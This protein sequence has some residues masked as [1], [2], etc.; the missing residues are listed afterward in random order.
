MGTT[1][2]GCLL[3]GIHAEHLPGSRCLYGALFYVLPDG[4]PFGPLM[5]GNWGAPTS[6]PR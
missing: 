1:R 2:I 5:V 6:S 4:V 3:E